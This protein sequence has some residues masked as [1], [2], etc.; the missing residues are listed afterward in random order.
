[1]SE[2]Q[3]GGIDHLSGLGINVNGTRGVSFKT[4]IRTALSSRY[5]CYGDA[6]DLASHRQ[7]KHPKTTQVC[8]LA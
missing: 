3:F 4:T 8:T 6:C 2:I 5:D 1:M 7:H